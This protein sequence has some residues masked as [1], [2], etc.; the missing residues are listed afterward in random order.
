MWHN[1]HFAYRNHP[2]IVDYQRTL[3]ADFVY[4]NLAEDEVLVE[5][6]PY[7]DDIAIV[8]AKLDKT[9]G[10]VDMTLLLK[11]LDEKLDNEPEVQAYP[12]F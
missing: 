5:M 1:A 2:I 8:H 6:Y 4:D 7:A 9:W 12:E 3:H 10:K 11:Q